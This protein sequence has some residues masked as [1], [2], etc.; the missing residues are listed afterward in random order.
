[1]TCNGCEMSWN[2]GYLLMGENN[3]EILGNFIGFFGAEMVKKT[4]TFELKRLVYVALIGHRGPIKISTSTF[5]RGGTDQLELSGQLKDTRAA[6]S[7][8]GRGVL[9]TPESVS[10]N[11]WAVQSPTLLCTL[12]PA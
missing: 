1:M 11:G 7:C 12:E 5:N 4:G 8:R 10:T 9:T 2:R 3:L 6:T